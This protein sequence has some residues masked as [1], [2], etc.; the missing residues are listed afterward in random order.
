MNLDGHKVYILSGDLD[1]SQREKVIED[2]RSSNFRVLITTNVCSRGL[3]LILVLISVMLLR[4]LCLKRLQDHLKSAKGSKEQ[5][6]N[7]KIS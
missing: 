5:R 4:L 3:F 1:V 7:D 6:H 2:F